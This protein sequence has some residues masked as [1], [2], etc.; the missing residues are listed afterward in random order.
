MNLLPVYQDKEIKDGHFIHVL[1]FCQGHC[2]SK[3]CSAYYQS[4]ENLEGYHCCPYGLTSYV[5]LE[6]KTIFTGFRAK[7]IY[8]KE[9]SKLVQDEIKIYNP[10]MQQ[11][12]INELLS[13]SIDFLK[14]N[15]SY[16]EKR[17]AVESV[18][19]EAKKLNAQIK[20]RCDILLQGNP[21]LVEENDNYDSDIAEIQ[22]AI[23]TIYVSSSMVDS[24][25]TMFNYEKNPE[26]LKSGGTFE[27]VVYKKFHKIQKIFKNYQKKNIS[28]NIIGESY[29][30]INAFSSFELIPVLIVEN[31]VKYACSHDKSVKIQ[32]DDDQQGQLTVVVM[33]YSP[34][35]SADDISHIFEKGFRGK[36]AKKVSSDGSG[37]GLYF[38][39]LLCDIHDIEISITSDSERITQISGIPYAPFCVRLKFHNVF[40]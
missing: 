6:T 25:F 27:C 9:K 39:K 18:S 12:Q 19:H 37:I 13:A 36:N 8:S 2:V 28:I 4:I 22:T 34:Y 33:S 40:Y 38:V 1:P 23:K 5:D 16:E 15:Q 7:N 26:V 24:R 3:K 11:E 30:K 21:Y 35:C 20:E 17:A 32:I 31:A 29:A 10:V 14:D